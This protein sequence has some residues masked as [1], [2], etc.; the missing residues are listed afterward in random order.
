MRLLP[1]IPILCALAAL[2]LSL[3]VLLAG[4]KP[5]FLE[6]ANLLTVNASQL[7][8]IAAKHHTANTPSSTLNGLFN[9]LASSAD[10]AYNSVV[11][12]AT[13]KLGLKDFYSAHMLDYC[14][15]FYTPDANVSRTDA[16]KNVTACSATGTQFSFNVTEI[17]QKQLVHGVGL[18]DLGFDSNRIHDALELVQKILLAAVGLYIAGIAL[19]GLSFLTG[20]WSLVGSGAADVGNSVL[21]FLAF[22][23]LMAAS[24]LATAVI[25]KA[26]DAVNEFRSIGIVAYKGTAFLGMTWT[27]VGLMLLATVLWVWSYFAGRKGQG[28]RSFRGEKGTGYGDARYR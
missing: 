1:L 7:G 28:R 6:S 23:I 5:D 18:S 9:S 4:T 12:A 26:V 14:E 17:L 19:T 25:S 15:G 27:A 10:A 24:A 16:G 3:L 8:N 13:R 11:D 20:I 22:L 21:A 2:I